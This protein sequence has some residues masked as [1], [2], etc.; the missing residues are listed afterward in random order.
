M[1]QSQ[2]FSWNVIFSNL[3]KVLGYTNMGKETFLYFAY[4]SNLLTERIHINNP[5]AKFKSIGFL[6]KHKLDFNNKSK[7]KLENSI[8]FWKFQFLEM[9]RGC[10]DNH[11]T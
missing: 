9:G 8:M 7:V 4:G 5:S 2:C 1:L 3:E 6:K 10:S 11:S